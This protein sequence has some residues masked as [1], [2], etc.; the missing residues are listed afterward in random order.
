MQQEITVFTE[1]DSL[2]MLAW[3]NV[4][5]FL[6]KTLEEKG[7][8][9]HRVDVSGFRILRGFYNKVLRPLI[10]I[11]INKETTFFYDRSLLFSIEVKL[12]MR[13]AVKKYYKSSYFI[14]T[15]FSFAPISYTKKP[16]ILFCDWTYAY[17]FTH[18]LKRKPDCLELKEI[19]RQ[20]KLI[21]SADILFV[22]FPNVSKHMCKTY[23]NSNIYYIGNIINQDVTS[24]ETVI[25]DSNKQSSHNILFV[26]VEKYKE[27]ALS[28]IAA[29]KLLQLKFP[30]ITVDIIGINAKDLE[31]LGNLPLFVH[32]HGYLNKNNPKQKDLYDFLLENASVYVNTTPIWAGFSSSLEVLFHK[33]PIIIT[34]YESFIDTFGASINFG[35]YCQ[36]NSPNTI[37]N[38]IETVFNLPLS[39]YDALCQNAH[40]A[41]KDFT[42]DNYVGK[43]L[44]V[45]QSKL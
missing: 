5:Y 19:F 39:A 4:P 31:E 30:K 2:S 26:G 13:L 34:P 27:G 37:A 38:Y 33:I 25:S 9:V 11:F 24:S 45:I 41:V 6:T 3:S 35:Y 16:C 36:E 21:E 32:C 42:W 1:G 10:Q 23:Q 17:Y 43:M 20:N 8:L 40:A 7:Y 12:R 15:S 18:F 14:S 28:L 22:L 44:E 29:A